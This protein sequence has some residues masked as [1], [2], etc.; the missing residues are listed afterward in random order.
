M[1]QVRFLEERVCPAC[2][3]ALL[4][5]A[6]KFANFAAKTDCPGAPEPRGWL[7]LEVEDLVS[8]GI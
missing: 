7:L 1:E 6:V 2:S 4:F 8:L 3:V 5:F